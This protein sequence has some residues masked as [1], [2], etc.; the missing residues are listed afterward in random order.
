MR[1]FVILGS[2]LIGL[3]A[4]AALAVARPP[5]KTKEKEPP[6]VA[7]PE[8]A[9]IAIFD[10]MADVYAKSPGH[11]LLSP[12]EY[13]G[14]LDKLERLER[15]SARALARR[16]SICSLEGKVAG[17][18]LTFTAKFEFRT[19]KADESVRLACGQAQATG[20]SLD[21][22]T[23]RLRRL[24]AEKGDAEG[25]V[26]EID[27]P[28]EHLLTLDLVMAIS[29]KSGSQGLTL[30]L[31]GAAITK[32]DVELPQKVRDVRLGGKPLA[33]TVP[34]LAGNKLTGALGPAEKLELTWLPAQ[35]DG[36]ATV[37]VAEG[38]VTARLDSKEL[39]TEARLTLRVQ[40][41]QVKEWK[42]LVP[43]NAELKFTPEEQSRI[44]R[45]EVADQKPSSLRTIH[46]KAMSSDPLEVVVAHTQPAPKPAT[47]KAA[48]IG[49]F[50]VLGATRHAG[51][52]LVCNAVPTWHPEFAP[53]G[54][55]TRRSLTDDEQRR[56]PNGVAAFRYGPGG[57]SG[58]WLDVEVESVRGQIKTKASH[59]LHVKADAGGAYWHLLTA[60]EIAPRWAD[61]DHLTIQFPPGCTLR[62]EGHFPLPDRVQ[63]IG[64]DPATR[65]VTIRLTRAI[66]GERSLAPI[67]VELEGVFSDKIDL[68]APGKVALA[69]PKPD[70]T[71][72]AEGTITVTVPVGIEL[73]AP[74]EMPAWPGL[75]VSSQ[76]AQEVV[77]R[78]ARRAPPSLALSW[79]PH[80][81]EVVV[82]NRADVTLSAG[83][84]RV[85]QELRF[86]WPAGP[87][88]GLKVR[89]PRE[90][91]ASLRTQGG[92]L[93]GLEGAP[94]AG[95]VKGL[96]PDETTRQGQTLLV[97]FEYGYPLS[98]ARDG[99]TTL[100]LVVPAGDARG[101]TR[102]RLWSDP[103][104]LPVPAGN[105]AE[106]NIEVVPGQPRL[107][108]LVLHSSKV[109][110][111]L[112]VV[113]GER[114]GLFALV[115]RSLVQ[116]EIGSNGKQ[117]YRVRYRLPRLEGRSLDFE[118]LDPAPTIELQAS[119]D[120]KRIDYD[121]LQTEDAKMK[122]RIVRL[123][124]PPSTPG[125]SALLEL[126][127]HLDSHGLRGTP[128]TT[129]LAAPKLLGEPGPVP[130]RWSVVAPPSYVVLG[131]EMG[132][133]PRSWSRRGWLLA[134]RVA[135]PPAELERWLL[136]ADPPAGEPAVAPSLVLWHDASSPV[137][138]IHLPQ[139]VWL[140]VCSLG[141][142]LVGLLLARLV[143][144]KD[145]GPS[146]L[147]VGLVLSGFAA[148]LV[149]AGLYV[150]NLLGQLAYGCQPG[151][152]VL[153][154]LVAIQRLL[155]ERYRRQ[156]VFLPSF[157]RASRKGSSLHRPEPRPHGQPSTIDAP[158]ALGSSIDR[159]S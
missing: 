41:G 19:D 73:L 30:D 100:P 139:Q 63:S 53:H 107:P 154:V 82:S 134:P 72:P 18:L 39:T 140:L 144:N 125:A 113:L 48:S 67:L 11:I 116:V 141:L 26:V 152:L 112:Q 117:T 62:E 37:T 4:W 146:S 143:L 98:P 83:G 1:R 75:E 23:P 69:L 114:S 109:D 14:M 79:R 119:L 94:G 91:V 105:W 103:G 92:R 101:D 6:Q 110:L 50:V 123:R 104:R 56:E 16:P 13:Q 155:H 45:V 87:A 118:L 9:I 49:P 106:Q 2:L 32:I 130:T 120:G 15:L 133:T 31:P 5:D 58:P 95:G 61:I 158:R 27:T 138:L 71:A 150:P 43:A 111:P 68:A 8:D 77:L 148:V 21:G 128:L 57:G 142:V 131:P 81:P 127:Y 44:A 70:G 122:N 132:P 78:Y 28:G 3:V 93:V 157:T 89:V 90:V 76:T 36:I 149:V 55:L 54:D 42:L 74:E 25:F 156:I 22:R 60:L 115:D 33:D 84:V 7:V 135:V 20:V 147:R 24:P 59:K 10:R 51:S 64:Q 38:I 85:R 34:K 121:S 159:I 66:G 108:V 145:G 80:R 151:V 12:K 46:L 52:L 88:P 102:I 29:S 124:L 35:S 40:S 65:V 136:D 99:P 97:V 129:P 86:T 126:V 17:N 137:R 96:I 153:V 47:G